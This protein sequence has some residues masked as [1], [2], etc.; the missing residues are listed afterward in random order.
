M[1]IFN[2]ITKELIDAFLVFLFKLWHLY[3][4]GYHDHYYLS[5]DIFIHDNSWQNYQKVLILFIDF[6][7]LSEPKGSEWAIV[8]TPGPSSV[9]HPPTP[10]NDFSS[11]TPGPI[12]FKLLVEPVKGQLKIYTNGQGWLSKMAAILGKNL[13]KNQ[14]SFEA[15]SWYIALGT[16][17]L[18]TLFK[19]WP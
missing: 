4:L 6:F 1:I 15:E 16:Q 14:E 18:P 7:S 19:W 2:S 8:I 13:P 10:L 5:Y 9:D 11:E 3:G 17:G 12:F